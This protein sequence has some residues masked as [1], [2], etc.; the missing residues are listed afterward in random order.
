MAGEPAGW[1]WGIDSS[2]DL[3]TPTKAQALVAD[4]VQFFGQALWTGL[5]QP[6]ACINNV[7]VAH[8]AG[9]KVLGYIS[10]APGH[11]GEWHVKQA[12]A[13]LGAVNWITKLSKAPI[14][15]EL[16]GLTFADVLSAL[17]MLAVGNAPRD[18][19]TNYNTWVNS[20]GNPKIPDGVGLWDANWD[21]NPYNAT[22]VYGGITPD[23]IFGM[24][25]TGGQDVDGQF[26]DRDVFLLSAFDP[27]PPSAKVV[28]GIGVHFTDGTEE[29]VWPK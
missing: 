25:Y 29:K 2:Y 5:E 8:D 13:K 27:A 3:L 10:I 28:D 22:L 4:G 19:Y 20:L 7:T 18:I 12:Y 24:Q 9:M 16:P 15:V 11:A 6:A 14:D 1:G 17:D 21:D 23:R 26:A